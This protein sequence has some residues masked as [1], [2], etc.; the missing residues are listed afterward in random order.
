MCRS[1]LALSAPLPS[2]SRVINEIERTLKMEANMSRVKHN[3]VKAKERRFKTQDTPDTLD[4]PSAPLDET[5]PLT[6]PP[7][8]ISESGAS[9]APHSLILHGVPITPTLPT[10]IF[11]LTGVWSDARSLCMNSPP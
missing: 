4:A 1:A 9:L 3:K 5:I 8:S 6:S 2:N 7:T 11:Q 10:S